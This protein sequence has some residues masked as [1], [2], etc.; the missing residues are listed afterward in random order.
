MSIS[1]KKKY[2]NKFK[3]KKLIAS[4]GFSLVYQGINIKN[5]EPVAM[6][7]EKK[8]NIHKFLESEAMF[9]YNLKGLGIPKIISY[10]ITGNYNLL[11]EE[12]LD[13][14][15]S[16]IWNY[17][18]QM[19][20]NKLKDVCMIG[21]QII[22]RLEFVHSKNVIHR[23]IKPNNILIGRKDP[24]NLYLIDFGFARKY[25]SSRTG[26]HIKYNLLKKAV[27]Y[28]IYLSANGNK[29]YEISRRDDLE[30]LGYMLIYLARNYLPWMYINFSKIDIDTKLRDICNMKCSITPEELCKGL[31]EDFVSYI[32]YCKNLE[33][34]QE[35]NYNYLRSLFTSILTRNNLKN[36]C[37]FYWI[38][39]Q[40]INK[41]ERFNENKNNI[42][43]RKDSAQKRLYN[44]IKLSLSKDYYNQNLSENE[45]HEKGLKN[46]LSSNKT[47][48]NI[49][50]NNIKNTETTLNNKDSSSN[51]DESIKKNFTEYT[52]TIQNID[53]H[54]IKDKY[55]NNIINGPFS[56]NTYIFNTYYNNNNYSSSKG[57]E[58]N[59]P[60][61]IK[62]NKAIGNINNIN[63][64]RDIIETKNKSLKIKNL[65]INAK[66][67]RTIKSGINQNNNKNILEK[68]LNQISHHIKNKTSVLDYF[69]NQE[70]FNNMHKKDLNLK[71]EAKSNDINNLFSHHTNAKFRLKEVVNYNTRYNPNSNNKK[72][73][74]NNNNIKNHKF[75]MPI[76]KNSIGNNSFHLSNNINY[77]S[78]SKNINNNNMSNKI[79]IN[80]NN[81]LDNDDQNNINKIKKTNNIT[82][83]PNNYNMIMN[84]LSFTP[85][86]KINK[87]LNIRKNIKSNKMINTFNKL[88]ESDNENKISTKKI[89]YNCTNSNSNNN[90]NNNINY[91]EKNI[92]TIKDYNYRKRNININIINSNKRLTDYNQN[93]FTDKKNTDINSKTLND[94]SI[95]F[96]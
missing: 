89:N 94:D 15:L 44:R 80:N 2:F 23:D 75:L 55:T 72:F 31:P 12:L 42:F 86:L 11:I 43:K 18:F 28:I 27:G 69:L 91:N 6:K 82:I 95:S 54:F 71:L 76:V 32:K 33:F 61:I 73:I 36:D 66:F 88:F 45:C 64:R 1:N 22:D 57:N 52:L 8:L 56:K 29:G 67:N 51:F 41:K 7:F 92:S 81:I 49:D 78:K 87:N 4:T 37:K 24:N 93:S 84:E 85:K 74:K 77:I 13:L 17:S 70:S 53:K 68:D 25:R 10:G 14:S 62:N 48:N 59:I 63:K 20:E 60:N 47:F 19:Y 16:Q 38:I 40:K 21:I 65:N 30:S 79:V 39:K 35:P 3:L 9:L 34:E 90:T 5:N 46:N 26:K 96:L 83:R 50:I 58:V